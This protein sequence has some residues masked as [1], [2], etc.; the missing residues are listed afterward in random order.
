MAAALGIEW[1]ITF[2]H[3]D[4][5]FCVPI[6][7]VLASLFSIYFFTECGQDIQIM[8]YLKDIYMEK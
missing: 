1:L 4:E 7:I 5:Q 2:L 6:Q 3:I 8:K